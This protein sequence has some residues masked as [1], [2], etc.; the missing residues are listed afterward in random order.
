MIVKDDSEAKEFERCLN[1]FTP[2]VDGLFVVVTGPSGKHD[3]IHKLVKKFGGTSISTNPKT[4]PD[5]Y[6][7]FDGKMSFADFSKARQVSFDMVT[8]DYEW[9]IWADVD[10]IIV[11]GEEIRKIAEIA[12]KKGLDSVLCTY[13]YDVMLDEDKNIV[14]VLI[15]Q[16]RERL[17]RNGKFKW[18]SRLH[19]VSV[20]KDDNYKPKNSLYLVD[21]KED[22]GLVWVHMTT[23]DRRQSAYKRN[24][25]I[26]RLQIE[27]T[28]EKDPRPMF[29]ISRILFDFE[30][31]E[32]A[33]LYLTKYLKLSGWPEERANAWL[34]IGM[35][36]K[37]N[38]DLPKALESFM[39]GVNE[40]P[41]FLLNQLRLS[42]VNYSLNNKEAGD[43]WLDSVAKSGIDSMGNQTIVPLR[44]MKHLEAVLNIHRHKLEGNL[45]EVIKWSKVRNELMGGGGEELV[46]GALELKALNFA[47]TAIFNLSKWLK[48]NG[49]KEK[50]EE[51]LNILPDKLINLEFISAITNNLL[52]P[53]KWDKDSIVY[54]A[55]FG[56]A[57]FEKWSPK[58]LK[59]GIGGS[60]TA[61][62]RLSE[63][64]AKMGKD[65][66][67]YCDCGDDAGEYNGVKYVHYTRFNF[68]DEFDTLILWRSPHLLDKDIKAEKLYMDL[69]DVASPLD[70]DESRWKKVDKIFVKS[71][72]HR[73]YLPDI[74]DNK[75][76]IIGNGI[77]EY[78]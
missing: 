59:H 49:Y 19:E 45:D 18:V 1:S 47:A 20:P 15:S 74:P 42:E 50:V 56:G 22:I 61:V 30:Q 7:K 75:F 9:I 2:H 70:W 77:D 32:E 11:S 36:H 62:I 73:S 21:P 52:P 66:T 78:E 44:Q 24:L 16:N 29:Y 60:E 6:H 33:F 37:R 38:G 46:E 67:V 71:K 35:I 55:S 58:S 63:E 39:R 40:Y 31:D 68:K 27:E 41:M 23:Q 54:F 5:I 64:W 26:L 8:K 17:L 76:V 65:V 14:D 53:K 12:Y 10:D 69:H 57:H 34:Y 13:W 3:K 25:D 43:Y 28:Q 51:L 48:D 4:H 72:H